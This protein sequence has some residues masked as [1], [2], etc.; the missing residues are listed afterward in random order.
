MN[1]KIVSFLLIFVLTLVIVGCS[2]QVSTTKTDEDTSGK[3][4]EE[5]KS[6]DNI[7]DLEALYEFVKEKYTFEDFEEFKNLVD[8]TMFDVTGNGTD[9]AIL[10]EDSPMNPIIF[11]TVDNG[12]FEIIPSDIESGQY[13]TS[14][15]QAGDFILIKGTGGGSG[16]HVEY[17]D[18][19]YFTGNEIKLVLDKLKMKYSEGGSQGIWEG[20]ADIDFIGNDYNYED[21]NYNYNEYE[22]EGEDKK[23]IQDIR[24][25]Y[26]FDKDSYSFKIT[27]IDGGFDETKED[28]ETSKEDSLVLKGKIVGYAAGNDCGTSDTIL[29]DTSMKINGQ[30]NGTYLEKE[31][32]TVWLEDNSIRKFIPRKYFTFEYVGGGQDLKEEFIE[33]ISVEVEI[34]PKSIEFF[35]FYTYAKVKKVISVDGENNPRDKSKDDYPL[36]YY[37]KVFYEISSEVQYENYEFTYDIRDYHFYKSD[38]A[39]EEFKVAVDKILESGLYINMLE[40]TY[41]I[42][43]EKR[44]SEEGIGD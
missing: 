18:F 26:K 27:P 32:S 12:N 38:D 28:N 39:I 41:E 20:E 30:E 4:V 36:D 24:K 5:I 21:F 2:K 35:D 15:T 17:L 9:E 40:G 22:G 25:N 14:I 6:S 37:K 33:K 34:D 42:D 10:V 19:A 1:K 8:C 7:E 43:T 29:L 11:V 31:I 3:K 23:H 16:M 13:S 44:N